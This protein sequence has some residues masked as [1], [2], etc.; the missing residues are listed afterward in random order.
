[1][2]TRFLLMARYNALPQ[3]SY[4]ACVQVSELIYAA[5]RSN[6]KRLFPPSETDKVF[7]VHNDEFD[8]DGT[9]SNCIRG[10]IVSRFINTSEA[11]GTDISQQRAKLLVQEPE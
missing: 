5:L 9:L 7:P 11:L 10:T 3:W 6:A 4:H 8:I 2:D 1:M